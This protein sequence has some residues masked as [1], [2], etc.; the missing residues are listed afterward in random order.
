MKCLTIHRIASSL[1]CFITLLLHRFCCLAL[2][3][4]FCSCTHAEV[5]IQTKNSAGHKP[6]YPIK[7]QRIQQIDNLKTSISGT[8]GFYFL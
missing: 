2:F 5:G 3:I 1:Y 6:P 8:L 7:N 4:S